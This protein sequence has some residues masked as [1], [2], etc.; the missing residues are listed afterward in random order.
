MYVL[1]PVSIHAPRVGRDLRLLRH[2]KRQNEFQSTRPVWGATEGDVCRRVILWVSIHA[3]RV[4]RDL[5]KGY[6][7]AVGYVSIHAPRVG[8]DSGKENRTC[9]KICFNP[10]APCGARQALMVSIWAELQFQS[11][12]PVWGATHLGYRRDVLREV[13]IHAPRVGR[14]SS[15]IRMYSSPMSFNPRA[16]CGARRPPSA[17][18]QESKCFNPRAPCGARPAQLIS[19]VVDPTFQSTRPVW[20][21][22]MAADWHRIERDVSIHAPRVGR[23]PAYS[24]R[25]SAL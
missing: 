24:A 23:D 4:G 14:D 8:R 10:R 11:T 18:F 19:S 20:G 21:A 12:R 6:L 16:P 3:P 2:A 25:P 17:C 7:E 22:T 1:S 5:V 9:G 15:P 13:S